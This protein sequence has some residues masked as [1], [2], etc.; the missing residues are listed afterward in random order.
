MVTNTPQISL[1]KEGWRR[2]INKGLTGPEGISLYKI[3]DNTH[4]YAITAQETLI[5]EVTGSHREIT[6][7]GCA[8]CKYS[9]VFAVKPSVEEINNV[10]QRVKYTISKQ[11]CDTPFDVTNL[12]IEIDLGS[13]LET[14][15]PS[16]NPYSFGMKPLSLDLWDFITAKI[17]TTDLVTNSFK[18][19]KYID[20]LNISYV[21]KSAL[22]LK[23]VELL[24][25]RYVM[26]NQNEKVMI[27]KSSAFPS[28]SP[29]DLFFNTHVLNGTMIRGGSGTLALV[30]NKIGYWVNDSSFLTCR[31]LET[32]SDLN[33][34]STIY[35]AAYVGNN[36]YYLSQNIEYP[37]SSGFVGFAYNM[38]DNQNTPLINGLI[39]QAIYFM[40][41]NF[42]YDSLND[43]YY[44]QINLNTIATN[45]NIN[46]I[47]EKVGGNI[48]MKFVYNPNNINVNNDIIKFLE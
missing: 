4:N 36:V 29:F 37:T 12:N 39:D 45:S 38:F 33:V 40:K 9:G 14:L 35:P 21:T 6:D 1:T 41:S 42:T 25:P 3:G 8:Y 10:L 44:L 11:D 34:Y 30:P 47:T 27:D 43:L 24:S 17:Q 16:N 13:W 26:V 28:S 48:S 18:D 20:N 19:V 15:K 2:L 7:V 23:N 22:D 46:Y 31:E 32:S 5:P